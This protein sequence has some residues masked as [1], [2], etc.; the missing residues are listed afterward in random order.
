MGPPLES[1]FKLRE[2]MA[3][4]YLCGRYA[5]GAV[6]VAWVTSGAPV[7]LL[8]PYGF[9]VYYPENHAA[10]CAARHMTKDL[11]LA[12]EETGLS[13]DVC[14]YARSDI[15]GVIADRT[16]VGGLPRPDLLVACT[17]ICQTVMY[18]YK[19]LERRFNVPLFVL[20]TPFIYGEGRAH[21]EDYLVR[22]FEELLALCERVSGRRVSEQEMAHGIETGRACSMAWRDVL[23]L[24][25]NRPAPM[26]AFDAFVHLAP[27]VSLRGEPGCLEYYHMLRDELADR[28]AKGIGGIENER[29]RLLWDNLPIWFMMRPLGRLFASEGFNFVVSTY[30]N[31]WAE[32]AGLFDPKDPLRSGAA[33]YSKIILNR[34]L[35]HKRE[36]ILRLARDYECDGVVMHSDRSCKPYSVGQYDLADLFTREH[37]LRTMVLE[38]DHGDPRSYSAEQGE[39]RVRAFMETFE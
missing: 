10:I 23:E 5:E 22:Q 11:C 9:H 33:V 1:S 12:V 18:W 13:R 15:G 8:R 24:C 39:L 36:L 31:A 25:R 3:A 17:N 20:D 6:P 34:D 37:G 21:D 35:K 32:T 7:E 19:D 27:V 30:T 28:V 2:L 26:T 4:H 38:A 14:S 29:H 16:P